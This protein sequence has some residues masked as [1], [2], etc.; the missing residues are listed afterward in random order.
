MSAKGFLEGEQRTRHLSQDQV[1]AL[2]AAAKGRSARDQLML[3]F[4]YRFAL[5]T[6]ELCALPSEAVNIARWEITIQGAKGGLRRAYTIPSDLRPLMRKHKPG[7]SRYFVGRRGPLGR[8]RV[9]RVFKA[10][11]REA[12]IPREFAMHSLR[13]SAAVHALD[14]GLS[15]EDVRDLLRHARL[16]TTD[17]Y[18]VLSVRRR[19]DYL[20]RLEASDAVVKLR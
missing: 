16:S 13:H 17:R 20:K 2:F 10:T 3:A 11:A 8:L 7:A 15:T 4:A 19:S 5:R 9:W 12:G 18:A 6:V 14:A 1:R